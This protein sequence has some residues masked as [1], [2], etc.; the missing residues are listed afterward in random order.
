MRN[1]ERI[2]LATEFVN[3]INGRTK[4]KRCGDQPIEWHRELHE[5]NPNSRVS[6]LRIQGAS[7]SR[8]QKEIELC[9]PFCRRCHMEIDGRMKKLKD[10]QPYQ[11]GKTYV[12]RLPCSCCGKLS[13]PLRNGMCSGCDNH[14]SGRR[15]R[16]SEN[17]CNCYVP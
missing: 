9:E 16:K 12:P 14:H 7:I 3:E 5:L 8:I 13:K 15:L 1:K 6:S 4:C 10:N 2:R 17:H 11:K